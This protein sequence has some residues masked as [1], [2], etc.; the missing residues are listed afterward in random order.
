MLSALDRSAITIT[1]AVEHANEEEILAPVV[2]V[3]LLSDLNEALLELALGVEDLGQVFGYIA[4]IH[5]ETLAERLSPRQ[6]SPTA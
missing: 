5:A 3:D 6:Q 4:Q 1:R 2:R